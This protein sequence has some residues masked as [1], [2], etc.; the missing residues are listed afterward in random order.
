MDR[1][2]LR[3]AAKNR[4]NQSEELDEPKAATWGCSFCKRVFQHEKTFMNHRCPERDKIDV[5]RSATGQAAYAHYGEW[6]KLKKRTVPPI[7]TFAESRY[8]QAFIRFAEHAVKT[9]IP[10]VKVFIRL[11]VEHNDVSP[12]LWCRDSVYALYLEWYDQAYPPEIQVI[13]TLDFLKELCSG[14]S[15]PPAEIFKAVP[16]QTLTSYIGRRKISPWFLSAS[17]VFRQHLL[18]ASPEDKERLERSM[19]LGAMIARIQ[20]DQGL[21]E[22]FGRVTSA[23]GF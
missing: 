19:N 5:L 10:N 4:R 3:A 13:E 17:K 16:V 2:Q 11:M 1:D 7:E 6:M 8:F 21:F 15:V 9:Q 12:M 14:Y 23:E 20:K 18:S 22:L